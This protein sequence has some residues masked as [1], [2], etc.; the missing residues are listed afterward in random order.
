MNSTHYL[1]T[2]PEFETARVWKKDLVT[3][4]ADRED[5]EKKLTGEAPKPGFW[6]SK[7]G[8]TIKVG[9]VSVAIAGA[10]VLGVLVD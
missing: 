7:T 2:R 4:N 5:C 9:G 10:F 3:C 8:F 6:R 1:L